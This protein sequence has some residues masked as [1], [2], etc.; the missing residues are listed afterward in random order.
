MK[1]ALVEDDTAKKLGELVPGIRTVKGQIAALVD[2]VWHEERGRARKV[3]AA[4]ERADRAAARA[5]RRAARLA[6]ANSGD[7]AERAGLRPFARPVQVPVDVS[8][9]AASGVSGKEVF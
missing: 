9:P 7:P 2:R 3:V 8:G 6:K 4:K 5:E 1:Q